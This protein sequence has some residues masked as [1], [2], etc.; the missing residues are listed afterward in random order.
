MRLWQFLAVFF[1]CLV[2]MR[3]G[4]A[5]D[6]LRATLREY[7]IAEEAYADRRAWQVPIVLLILALGAGLLMRAL[8]RI[9][10]SA[11]KGMDLATTG[12]GFAALLM[13][14]LIALRIVS[15]HSLDA[16]LYGPLKINWFVDI[17]CAIAVMGCAIL[18]IRSALKAGER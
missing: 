3:I 1:I 2:A 17:G 13:S 9:S 15:L 4:G 6:I 8:F 5:E 11:P 18:Y 16:L 14:L 7:L 10:K 12:A